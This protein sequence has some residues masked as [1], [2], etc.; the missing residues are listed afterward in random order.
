MCTC[1]SSPCSGASPDGWQ[2]RQRGESKT[3]HARSKAACAAAASGLA[4]TPPSALA[5]ARTAWTDCDEV[6]S[7]DR[8]CASTGK[9]AI[10]IPNSESA[11]DVGHF[12]FAIL[13]MLAP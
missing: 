5:A 13:L 6:A 3:V 12:L 4:A 9:H 7:A 11:I 8:C 2:F 1:P 10:K